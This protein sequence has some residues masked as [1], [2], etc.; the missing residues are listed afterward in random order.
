[1]L[2]PA[3]PAC[4]RALIGSW[5]LPRPPAIAAHLPYSTVM[6]LKSAHKSDLT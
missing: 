6:T 2:G 1:M 4:Y 3:A 5:L